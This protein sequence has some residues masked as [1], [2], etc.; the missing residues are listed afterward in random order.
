VVADID[1]PEGWDVAGLG[2]FPASGGT[3]IGIVD[4]G[5]VRRQGVLLEHEW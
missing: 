5:T 3:T 1:A 2:A 4:T